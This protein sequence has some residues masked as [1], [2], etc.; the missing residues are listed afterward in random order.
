MI[1]MK[2]NIETIEQLKYYAKPINE[3]YFGI[4]YQDEKTKNE[5]YELWDKIKNNGQWINNSFFGDYYI[6]TYK[7]NNKYYELAINDE[8]GIMSYIKEYELE[9]K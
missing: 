1:K 4:T 9:E 3:K 8:Y 5:R 2:K 6:S 7:Y